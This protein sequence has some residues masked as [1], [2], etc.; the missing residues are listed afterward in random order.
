MNGR[1]NAKAEEKK[2]SNEMISTLRVHL[3]KDC[4]IY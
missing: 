1:K 3:S 2:Q 4:V